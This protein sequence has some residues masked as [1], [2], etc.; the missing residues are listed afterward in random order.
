MGEHVDDDDVVARRNNDAHV[1]FVGSM[2][3]GGVIHVPLKSNRRPLRERVGTYTRAQEQ[4][5]I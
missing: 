5:F 2:I 1:F 3:R 4:G